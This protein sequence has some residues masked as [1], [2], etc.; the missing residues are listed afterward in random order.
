VQPKKEI[1]FQLCLQDVSY[2]IGI[3]KRRM[4]ENIALNDVKLV[5]L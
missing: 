4:Q 2:I 3:I 5:R 1:I